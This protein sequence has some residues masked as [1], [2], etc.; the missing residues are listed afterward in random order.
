VQEHHHSEQRI[1]VAMRRYRAQ[2]LSLRAIGERLEAAS[3]VPRSG[4]RWHPQT[5]AN[6]LNGRLAA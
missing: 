1:L 5:V 6:M 3:V 4:G 2:G